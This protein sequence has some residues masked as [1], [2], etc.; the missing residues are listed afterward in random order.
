MKSKSELKL[1]QGEF[2]VSDALEILEELFTFKIK[3]HEWRNYSS[4]ERFGKRDQ[5]SIERIKELKKSREELRELLQKLQESGTDVH[6]ESSIAIT[7]IQK[8]QLQL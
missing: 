6:I 2:E 1:I 5:T 4:E 8:S 3:F 7:A